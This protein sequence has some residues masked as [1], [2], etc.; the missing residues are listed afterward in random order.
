MV[1][2]NC[3][4]KVC[5]DSC[6]G[7]L[8]FARFALQ[9]DG[10]NRAETYRRPSIDWRCSLQETLKSFYWSLEPHRN[11]VAVAVYI[12][13]FFIALKTYIK[14]LKNKYDSK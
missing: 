10:E 14:P 5:L 13:L 2:W 9:K 8:R 3:L 4:F 12:F 6:I 1:S 11:Y 7:I